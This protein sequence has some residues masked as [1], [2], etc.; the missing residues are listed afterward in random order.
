MQRISSLLNQTFRRILVLC[1]IACLTVSSCLSIA[2]N[3]S[4]AAPV[5]QNS[6]AFG[7]QTDKLESREQA[8]EKAI[9][10]VDEPNGLEKVYEENLED[11]R[12]ENPEPSLVE[13]A[14]NAIKE[15]TKTE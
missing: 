8:Y 9:E 2:V 3:S 12:E 11:Y 4:I 7:K 5:N 10:A 13:Q 14:T 6:P 1:L 15:V